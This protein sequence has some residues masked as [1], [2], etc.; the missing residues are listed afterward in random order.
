M[1]TGRSDVLVIGAGPAGSAAA[2]SAARAGAK[3]AVVD[4]AVFPRPKTCGD[5]VSNSA[6]ALLR[7][8]VG[9][10]HVASAP[11]AI[12]RGAVGVF[13]D[14][15]R[16]R[17][18]YGDEPGCIMERTVLD[19]LLRR[20]A[21][22]AGAAVHENVTVRR[23]KRNGERFTGA[24]GPGLGWDADV[25]I[26]ANGSA[27]LAADALGVEPPAEDAIGI[28]ATA[29]FESMAEGPDPDFS[30]HYFEKFLPTGY[31]WIFPPVLGRANVG[32]YLRVDRYHAGKVKLRKLMDEFVARYPE[33]FG[34]AK[35]D[36]AMRSWSLPLATF[37]PPPCAPTLLSCGDAAR[38]IDPLT[39]E[40]IWHA[41]RTGQL[42]GRT[43][44]IALASGGPTEAA[45]GRY[46][47]AV[48]R[49]V[50]W[51]TAARRGIEGMTTFIVE[52]ELYRSRAVRRLLEWGYN[53]R[54]LEISKTMGAA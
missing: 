44:A 39:G 28:S 38:L 49:E 16:V 22:R 21:E 45:V 20:A 15:S 8:L 48:L 18:R 12:V 24:E 43:A 1:L 29:Y 13:P 54:A 4:K 25:V 47:R 36:G 3:V 37:R 7:E 23:L 19:D 9:A 50:M 33:R 51:P 6:L 34:S 53:R 42:A 40:G 5:A 31:G 35:Q 14:G 27:S 30:E 46:R 10:E 52:H 26:V 32:V 11:S 2:I 41:L 17:R